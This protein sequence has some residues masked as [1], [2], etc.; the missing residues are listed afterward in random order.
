MLLNIYEEYSQV[1]DNDKR[2]GEDD[3]F[4]DL[5]NK[6][7]TF[8]RKI[9]KWLRSACSDR[10]E[11]IKGIL[12]KQWI[13]TKQVIRKLKKVPVF[14]CKGTRRESKNSRTHGRGRV[15]WTKAVCRKSS[16]DVENSTRAKQEQIYG[17][18]DTKSAD[19]RSQL[20]RW[21][22]RSCSKMSVQKNIA[23]SSLNYH[24]SNFLSKQK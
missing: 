20:S 24:R 4:D 11:V 18:D 13:R 10:K 16:R 14:P 21:Q 22:N 19:D 3:W 5:D 23:Q 17:Q 7:C 15:Q 9:H 1:L 6:V 2:A 8:K 12:K